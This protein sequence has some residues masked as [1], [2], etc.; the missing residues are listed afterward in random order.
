M[1]CRLGGE[2]RVYLPD[3]IVLADDGRGATDPLHLVVEVKGRRLEDAKTK[4]ETLETQWLPGV[5]RM[6][7]YGRWG[8]WSCER[9]TVC[10]RSWTRRSLNRARRSEDHPLF[11]EQVLRKR[12]T[13]NQHGARM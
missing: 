1:P 8:S 5:N 9:C 6:G 12:P 4:K 2:A 11:P 10:A 7:D 13:S 3:F